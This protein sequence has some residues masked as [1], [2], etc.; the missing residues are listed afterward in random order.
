MLVQ[1]PA[2]MLN[3]G[4]RACCLWTCR[5]ESNPRQAKARDGSKLRV[6]TPVT[7]G[8]GRPN[9]H[10]E[11]A[12]QKELKEPTQRGRRTEGTYTERTQN[13]RNLHREGP[14]Q[15]ES[16]QS[17]CKIEGIDRAQS[18]RN[19]HRDSWAAPQKTCAVS[20]YMRT[21]ALRAL[22]HYAHVHAYM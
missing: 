1:K 16:I 3:K 4:S 12:E 9:R 20:M 6:A 22:L 8:S 5:L 7:G 11:G 13:R 2:N 21:H 17:G 14:E 10:R 15:K 18:R 19:L